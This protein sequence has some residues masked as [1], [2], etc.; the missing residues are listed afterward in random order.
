MV[1]CVGVR[2]S[3]LE[4]WFERWAVVGWFFQRSAGYRVSFSF[5]VV[6]YWV[7]LVVGLGLYWRRAGWRVGV[8]CMRR[9]W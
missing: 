2:L 9:V 1:W 4:G 5:G 3:S 8:R 7:G 6:G